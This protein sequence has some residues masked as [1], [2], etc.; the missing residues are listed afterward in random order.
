M[1]IDLEASETRITFIKRIEEK[2]MAIKKAQLKPQ[3]PMDSEGSPDTRI[4]P[5][6]C[7]GFSVQGN[8][9]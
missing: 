3:Q 1:G 6:T 2:I 7:S 5:S 4:V 8:V 9:I